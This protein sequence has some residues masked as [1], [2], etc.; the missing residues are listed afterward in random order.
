[1]YSFVFSV[2]TVDM[3]NLRQIH[4]ITYSY[5]GDCD[6]ISSSEFSYYADQIGFDLDGTEFTTKYY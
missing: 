3:V 5:N 6:Y 4:L 1:M 2:S